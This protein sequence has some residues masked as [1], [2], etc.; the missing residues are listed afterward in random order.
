MCLQA[1]AKTG[2]AAFADEH[3]DPGDDDGLSDEHEDAAHIIIDDD[4]EEEE[5]DRSAGALSDEQKGKL[6]Q[7][8]ILFCALFS[9]QCI[10]VQVSV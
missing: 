4:D 1:E 8:A 7:I 10:Q 3:A 6:L 9:M 5:D 2:K